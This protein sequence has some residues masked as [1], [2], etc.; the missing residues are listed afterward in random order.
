M[1]AAGN[2]PQRLAALRSYGILDTPPEASFDDLTVLAAQMCE[3]PIAFVSFIDEDRQWLK[4]KF[5]IDT[6]DVSRNAAFCAQAILEPE[7][8]LEVM[9]ATADPRFAQTEWVTGRHQVRFYAGAPL[10]DHQGHALGALCVMDRK[11]R[12][13]TPLQRDALTILSRHVV[14]QLE[15]RARSRELIEEAQSRKRAEAGLRQQNEKLT[16]SQRETS[17]LLDLAER[18]RGALL[19][20]LEDEQ[21][22]TKAL[23]RSNRALKMLSSCNEALIWATDETVLLKQICQIAVELGG[24]RM[25]WV[26]YAQDDAT[27]GITPMGQWGD[28]TGYLAEISFTWAGDQP[29]GQGPAGRCIREGQAIVC[30]DITDEASGFLSVEAAVARG[31][32]SVI[33]LPLQDKSRTFGLLGLYSDE[34]GEISESEVR[35]LQELADDL[36]FGIGTIRARAVKDRAEEALVASLREKEA[37]LKEVHHRVKNNLQV[38]ASLLRLEGR[39]IDHSITRSV[40]D[41]MQGRIQSMALLHETLYRSGN[42]SRVD[43]TA[44]LTQLTNQLFRSLA[45]QPG[46]VRLT[47]DLAP[48]RVDIDQ[49]IPCGLIVNELA[50]NS[51]KHGFPDGRRGELRITLRADA[52]GTPRSLVVS[53]DGVGLRPDFDVSRNRSLGLQLVSDLARQLQ[54]VLTIGPVPAARFEITFSKDRT[55]TGEIMAPSGPARRAPQEAP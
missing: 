34:V 52:D 18:S 32:R 5:G 2:E 17:R 42:F 46:T 41:Q 31:Y 27:R 4:A 6:G 14:A 29:M 36:A 11:P 38:I 40:L 3:A 7:R 23:A 43:L 16:H 44:Y 1:T 33:C 39:R 30:G 19:S 45:T 25:A 48:A 22:T 50:S 15:L 12:S 37:L 26:G 28:D 9:D 54:G 8:V 20:I 10:V 24:H 35:L 49:A 53:D 13:L 47:L 21:R 51:L 55:Q